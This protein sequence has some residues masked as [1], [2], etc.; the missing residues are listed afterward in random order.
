[1]KRL[2][3][4]TIA[5]LALSGC[6]SKPADPNAP[7]FDVAQDFLVLA[8]PLAEGMTTAVLANNPRYAPAVCSIADALDLA[9]KQTELTPEMVD[10]WLTDLRRDHP[11]LDVQSYN[12]IRTFIV[13]MYDLWRSRYGPVIP[14]DAQ[15][16]RVIGEI[17]AVIK[18]ACDTV[19][20][21]P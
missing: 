10:Y 6:I 8:K 14:S 16:G 15:A 13:A 18:R 19:W 3:I 21:K 11:E 20:D 12:L 4:L 5:V 1:M 2:A 9:L 7:P 17:Q